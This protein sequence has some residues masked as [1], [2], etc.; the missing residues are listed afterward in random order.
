MYWEFHEKGGRQAIRK[1]QWKAIKYNAF[2]NPDAPFELYNLSEDIGEVNNIANQ[3]PDILEDME[4]ILKKARTSSSVF[5][6]NDGTYLD[7]K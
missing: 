2:K 4:N 6:F 1:G 7:S 3:H 5:K